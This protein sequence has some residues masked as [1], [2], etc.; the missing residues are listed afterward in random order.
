MRK[1]I[2]KSLNQLQYLYEL[3]KNISIKNIQTLYEEYKKNQTR[4]NI[5]TW[6]NN[7]NINISLIKTPNTIY[8]RLIEEIEIIS[9]LSDT[10]YK[11]VIKSILSNFNNLTLTNITN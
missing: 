4:Y 5:Q 3:E 11:Q 10:P 8:Q 6:I 1:N 9:I 7:R 2:I